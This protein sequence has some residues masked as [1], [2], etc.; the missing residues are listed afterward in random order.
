MRF[1]LRLVVLLLVLAVAALAVAYSGLYNV[2]ATNQHSRLVQRFLMLVSDRSEEHHSAGIV[3]PD[4][5]QDTAVIHLGYQHFQEMCVQCHGAPGM[6]RSEMARGLNPRAPRLVYASR[7][8]PP[9]QLFWIVKN[10]IKMTGMPA[11]A[12]TH[13]DD[14]IWAITAFVKQL[15]TY[16]ST[17]Y[18]DLKHKWAERGESMDMDR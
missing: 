9:A 16:D 7:E 13:T 4:N 5:L 2:A 1:L 6:E 10:G 8:M 14:E 11:F 12:S 17:S 18:A 15:S 3:V